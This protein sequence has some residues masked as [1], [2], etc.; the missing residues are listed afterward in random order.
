MTRAGLVAPDL[1]RQSI[2]V[3]GMRR[4][5][6]VE[7][8]RWPAADG[9][10]AMS[11]AELC[12]IVGGGHTWPGGAQYLPARIVGP[13]VEGLVATGIVLDFVTRPGGPDS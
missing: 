13:A 2:T 12:R 7:R 3:N 10:G 5:F 8:L 11:A 1:P 9:S 6:V 4:T